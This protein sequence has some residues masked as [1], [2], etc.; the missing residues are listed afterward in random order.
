MPHIFSQNMPNNLKTQLPDLAKVLD[1]VTVKTAPWYHLGLLKSKAGLLFFSF[2]KGPKFA[3][4][5]YFD[6][7]APTL[8]A[9]LLVETWPNGPD[10][11][12]S[13]CGQFNVYNVQTVNMNIANCTFKTTN[14]H[15]KWATITKD[16]LIAKWICIGDINRAKPQRHRGGGSVCFQSVNVKQAYQDIIGDIQPC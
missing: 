4:E 3:K 5:L 8:N 7:I 15:S 2:A 16:N 9:S 14:D 12:P 11:L 6:W 1:D 10:R 13:Q